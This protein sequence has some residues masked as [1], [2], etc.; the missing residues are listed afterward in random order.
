MEISFRV[1]T[2]L[3]R[4]GEPRNAVSGT[5]L[6]NQYLSKRRR[7]NGEYLFKPYSED[8]VTSTGLSVICHPDGGY[9]LWSWGENGLLASWTV[10]DKAL[11]RVFP[12]KSD[13]APARWLFIQV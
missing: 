7:R 8:Y 9:E 1:I 12:D 6:D 2:G 3:S 4:R 10:Q 13:K 11:A 5:N